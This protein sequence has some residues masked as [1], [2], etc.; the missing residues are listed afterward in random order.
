MATLSIYKRIKTGDRW[1]YQRILEGR[2]HR[3]GD[4]TG[5]FYARPFFHGKQFW[6][7]LLAQNF[8]DARRE[9]DHLSAVARPGQSTAPESAKTANVARVPLRKAVHDFLYEAAK[10]KRPKTVTGYK[11]NLMQFV[12]CVKSRQFLDEINKDTLREFRDYLLSQGYE[13]RT[14]HNRLITILSL[15]KEHRIQT[16]FSL[17]NDLPTFEE[18]PPVPF[19]DEELKKIF[20]VMNDEN[21]IRYKFF[22]GTACREQEVQFASWT[23]IDFERMEF[24]VR[25]KQD[26]G[27]APKN[28]EKRTVPI[29]ASLIALLKQRKK[30]PLHTRWIFVNRN[31][32]PEGHFLKKLK[33]IALQAGINC[34]EC[35]TTLNK[36]RYDR[37]RSVQVTCKTDPVCKHFFLHRFRKTC[38]SRWEAAGI[39][40]RT[41]QA[42]LGHKDLSTTQRY[43]GITDSIKLRSKIE[44]AASDY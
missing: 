28:H 35:T 11:L 17:T 41:I 2:G 13:P 39:P 31:G 14:L 34:G 1:K 44:A 19:A 25:Q 16:G 24:H 42:W 7:T 21:R 43:L 10:K 3:T 29:P 18:D 23:D 6:K 15:L 26:I 27:F 38:A 20:A 37:K 30:N 33:R 32:V 8:L 22:L 5:P 4:L 9:A 12:A 36:G 40:V